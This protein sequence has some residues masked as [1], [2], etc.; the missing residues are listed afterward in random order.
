[1]HIFL[2]MDNTVTE[3]R[4]PITP[5]MFNVLEGFESLILVSGASK[6]QMKYQLRGLKCDIMAQN[7]NDNPLFSNVLKERDKQD[8]QAHIEKFATILD[9]QLEDRGCQVSYSFVGHHAPLGEKRKFDPDASHRQAILEAFPLRSRRLEVR[10]GGTTCLDY[11][12]KGCTK[13][14]NIARYI[15]LKG[16]KPY[17]CLYVGDALFPRGNDESVIGVI[18]TF[19]V[20]DPIDTLQFLS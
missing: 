20:G 4:T 12:L 1:M 9:D 15:K 19:P 13:G 5:E 3:S 10:I 11:F 8:I 18:P 17:E 7:G 16:W 6:E 14:T 2:D